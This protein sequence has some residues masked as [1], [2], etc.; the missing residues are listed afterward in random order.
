M[1][2]RNGARP[3]DA[4]RL[5]S[6]QAAVGFAA[7]LAMLVA[8][9]LFAAVRLRSFESA[10]QWVDHTHQVI[11][12]LEITGHRLSDA[13][14]SQRAY[15]V[16]GNA[17]YRAAFV[18]DSAAAWSAMRGLHALTTDNPAQERRLDTLESLAQAKLTE[19]SQTIVLRDTRGVAAAQQAVIRHLEHPLI[20]A[21]DAMAG[22]MQAAERALLVQRN[23]ERAAHF[24]WTSRA[25]LLGLLLTLVLAFLAAR[26]IGRADSERARVQRELALQSTELSAQNEELVAQGEALQVAMALAEGAN[27]A[28][29]AFLAQMSHELRTPL[30][31]VIGFA[32][33]V[34]RNPRGVLLESE[35]EYLDRVV[36]NGRHLLRTINS[37]L[38]LSKI[39]A[40]HETVELEL[41]SLPELAG[42]V[43]A[44]M[45]TQ[46]AAAVVSLRLDAPPALAPI[47]TDRDKLRRVLVNLTANAV[48][49]TR[50]GGSVVVRLEGAALAPTRPVAIE[51]VDTGVGIAPSRLAAIFEAFEQGDVGVGREF[52]G[53]GLGLSI[54]RALCRLLR[55]ELTVTSAVGTGSTFRVA[56][57]W[58]PEDGASAA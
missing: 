11:E 33:V 35:L 43:L 50:P 25:M 52:G 19:L 3:T 12:A 17:R 10:T 42:E 22:R 29:S 23:G 14:S 27:K 45:E 21:F 31:S 2:D 34:R 53:T 39:E 54:S 7:A 48:K 15:L 55:Y 24:R 38:D 1:T 49:F 8:A 57:M 40:N 47:V 13:E 30:N 44:T 51:V 41:V 26:R 56:L 6:T 37:I 16:S 4:R 36:E 20:A 5:L 58:E 28:K 9:A 32:N 18:S 46:A